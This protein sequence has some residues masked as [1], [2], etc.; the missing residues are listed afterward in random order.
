MPLRRHLARSFVL[1]RESVFCFSIAILNGRRGPLRRF[2]RTNTACKEVEHH[3]GALVSWVS[4]AAANTSDKFRQG[5]GAMGPTRSP[6]L[7]SCGTCPPKRECS[8]TAGPS[9][10]RL[11]RTPRG[12]NY[13]ALSIWSAFGPYAIGDTPNYCRLQLSPKPTLGAGGSSWSSLGSA[14]P[15]SPCWSPTAHAHCTCT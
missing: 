7:K 10:I 9:S 14:L 2:P 3:L 11:V 6:E 1:L 4:S 12:R 13:D 8:Y 15:A 5:L